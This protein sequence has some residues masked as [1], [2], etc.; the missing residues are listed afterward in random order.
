MTNSTSMASRIKTSKQTRQRIQCRRELAN[1]P[2]NARRHDF[3]PNDTKRVNLR[4]R[5]LKVAVW[6]SV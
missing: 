2:Y 3:T 6:A 1:A 4:E 5:L